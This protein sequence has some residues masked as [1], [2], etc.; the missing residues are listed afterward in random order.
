MTEQL[1]LF[2]K[3]EAEIR[4]EAFWKFHAEFPEVYA[5]LRREA[6]DMRRRGWK[7][8]GIRT[9]WEIARHHMNLQHGGEYKLN[10]HHTRFYARLLMKNESELDG[11]FETRGK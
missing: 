9:L 4:E 8:Y 7:R 10:D 11:F 5:R 1:A 3:L 2:P 6:L